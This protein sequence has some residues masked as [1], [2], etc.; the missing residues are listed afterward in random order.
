MG[1]PIDGLD[2]A[3]GSLRRHVPRRAARGCSHR[4][5][6]WS[7]APRWPSSCACPRAPSR[8]RPASRCGSRTAASASPTSR[9][10]ISRSSAGSRTAAGGGCAGGSSCR[11]PCSAATGSTSATTRWRSS[12]ASSATRR[13]CWSRPTTSCSPAAAERLWGVFAPAYSLR[14]ELGIG[15][16]VMDL[17]VLG[18]WID[19]YGGKVVGTLPLLAS[20]LDEPCEPEP[21]LAGVAPVL[22]RGLPRRRAAARDG[23]LARGPGPARRPRHPGRDRGHAAASR[24]STRPGSAGW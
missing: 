14:T 19:G 21:L 3:S 17:D 2:D 4:W 6:R 24:S 11:R 7:A 16:D 22:E 18:A 23:P 1:A 20:Y 10:P 15:A 9:S 13:R 8:G 12:C 5:S